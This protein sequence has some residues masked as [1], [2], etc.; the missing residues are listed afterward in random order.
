MFTH[1]GHRRSSAAFLVLS[2][3]LAIAMSLVS[4]VPAVQAAGDGTCYFTWQNPLPHGSIFYAH[5]NHDA[6]HVRGVGQFGYACSTADGG[7]T[8]TYEPTGTTANLRGMFMLN[9]STDLACGEQGTILKCVNGTWSTLNSG[10]TVTLYGIAGTSSLT[11]A[12]GA[13]GVIRRAMRCW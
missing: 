2:I 8:W 3:L 6:T 4:A 11:F 7:G 1:S 9:S 13:G 10:T 12:V 5:T